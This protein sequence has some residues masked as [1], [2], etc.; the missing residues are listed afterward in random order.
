MIGE[1]KTKLEESYQLVTKQRRPVT[2]LL[3][4]IK[5]KYL[6][7]SHKMTVIFNMQKTLDVM[8]FWK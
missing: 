8:K 5:S 2:Q 4:H 6:A 3:A 7:I 1:L